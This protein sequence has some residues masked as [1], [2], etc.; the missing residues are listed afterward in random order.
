MNLIERY[1][2]HLALPG[3]TSEHQEAMGRAR[4]AIVG[5][6]GLGSPVAMYLAAAGVGELSLVDFDRVN[7]SNIHRQVLFRES[8]IGLKKSD[9]A[10]NHI[11]QLNS[12]CKIRAFD[13]KLNSSNALDTLCEHDLIL[14]CSDNFATRY[15]I[16]DVSVKLGIPV[17]YAAIHQMEGQIAVFNLSKD[18]N[19][20]DVY[21]EPPQAGSIGN[22]EEEGVLGTMAGV[23]AT[24]QANESI[25]ILSGFGEIADGRM[26]YFDGNSCRT[27]IFEIAPNPSNFCRRT[28]ADAIQL[29]DYESYCGKLNTQLNYMNE[30]TVNE[31]KHLMDSQDNFQLIDVR[32]PFEFNEMN[33]GALLIPMNRVPERIAEINRD[34]KVI[35]HCKSGARSASVIQYLQTQHGFNNLSNLKGGILA[36]E[37]QFGRP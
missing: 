5:C 3:F 35:V 16:C 28:N 22:C 4:V 10:K 13:L 2:R 18:V 30:I 37:Q 29:I 12:N 20:R 14:D 36:W 32:E 19:Y 34:K 7:I 33:L 6:G 17:V 15:L 21:P 27:H 11:Q 26:I 8:D 31:L 9:A 23:I 1:S 25:K 24:M